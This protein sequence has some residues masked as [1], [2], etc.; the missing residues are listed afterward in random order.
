M[1]HRHTFFAAV[2]T[3]LCVFVVSSAA[4]VVPDPFY[5]GY[6]TYQQQQTVL[7]DG[8]GS[9]SVGPGSGLVSAMPN[10][11]VLLDSTCS[12]GATYPNTCSLGASLSITYYFEV[13]G[14]N[15]GDQVNVLMDSILRSSGTGANAESSVW[16]NAQVSL[17][18]YGNTVGHDLQYTCGPGNCG[19]QH[20]WAGT[21][22]MQM[23]VGDIGT[24]TIETDIDTEAGIT[25]CPGPNCILGLATA[26]T[27]ADPYIY[28]DPN[29]PNAWEYSIVVSNGIGNNPLGT[30]PEPSSL[31]LLGSGVAGLA[32]VLR[33]KLFR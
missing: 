18:A 15:S 6:M 26:S 25:G 19:Y 7:E 8:P 28:I 23:T 22:S 11:A 1:N 9:Y 10:P 30:T 13:T 24:V 16:T 31:M 14:G 4:G 32:G 17:S 21:L 20:N 12:A 5:Y 27:L 2:V 29:T 3:F 33:R